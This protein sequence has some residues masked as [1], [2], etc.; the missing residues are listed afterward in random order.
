VT[1]PI[2]NDY[3]NNTLKVVG[4]WSPDPVFRRPPLEGD[5]K[6]GSEKKVT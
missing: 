4:V 3:Q 5:G 1:H 6:L 2:F